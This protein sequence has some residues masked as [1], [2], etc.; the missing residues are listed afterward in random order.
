MKEI[1][2]SPS[3]RGSPAQVRT[4]YPPARAHTVGLVL[5]VAN[6]RA[7]RWVVGQSRRT[8]QLHFGRLEKGQPMPAMRPARLQSEGSGWPRDPQATAR[9]LGAAACVAAAA[10]PALVLRTLLTIMLVAILLQQ[11]VL[12]GHVKGPA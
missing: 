7:G 8:C 10:M 2:E 4:M 5:V 1:A 12:S 9:A 3:P 6:A 11:L